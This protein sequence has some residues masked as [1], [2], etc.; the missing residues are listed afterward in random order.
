LGFTL[1][2]APVVEVLDDSNSKMLETRSY[3][4]DADWVA[5]AGDA[6]IRGM[7]KGGL[8]CVIKHFPGNTNLDPHKTRPVFALGRKELENI[9]GHFAKIIKTS[10]PAGLMVSH[11][12]IPA[13]DAENN[14][15]L[16]PAVIQGEVRGVLGFSGIVL[17]D[18]LA[19][20]AVASLSTENASV[21]AIAA[22][23]D[24]V[25]VWP[26]ALMDVHAALL[27]ALK[28]GLI[29]RERFTEA[30]TRI[31]HEKLKMAATP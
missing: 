13:W 25:I 1:N 21:N 14:A 24:V 10:K 4:D 2:L 18:D 23:A 7:G 8:L 31:I 28:R 12:I 17:T 15:S 20:G 30:A 27:A 26:P 19:M 11:V 16:S 5:Q 29:P 3:G 6:F 9:E 22:G